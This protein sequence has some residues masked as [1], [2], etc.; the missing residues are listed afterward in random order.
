MAGWTFDFGAGAAAAGHVKVTTANAAYD[1]A[2]GW[3]FAAGGAISFRQRSGPDDERGDFC[4]PLGATFIIDAP[5]GNYTVTAL[6]GDAIAPTETVVKAAPGRLM[7]PVVRTEA[8][9]FA[10]H[11]FALRASG[12]AIRLSF[13]GSAPRLNALQIAAAPHMPTLYLAGDSTVTD[14]AEEMFPYAGWG[15][16]LPRWLKADVAVVN[17][18]KSG[19]SSRSFIGEGRLDAIAREL[20]PH[21]MLL[22]QFGHNDQKPDEER[23]T[24]PSSS[25]AEHLRRYVDVARERDVLPI[26][27]TPV[28][29]RYFLPGGELADTHGEYAEAVRRLAVE[30]DVPLV[31]LALRSKTL[32]EAL[33]PEGTKAVFM[34]AAPGE[35]MRFP[36]GVEDNTHFQE[37]GAIRIAG[38]V[39]EALKELRL[40]PLHK[41]VR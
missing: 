15:Q 12:G 11:S 8:G 7:L 32:F 5:D 20:K 35:F 24:E 1:S 31:D 10:R 34:W 38:L 17:F 19:R 36:G 16:M 6:F 29:R 14:E 25:Y 21:D 23:H 41:Y 22:V 2:R 33:G 28:Q 37:Q 3:G 30:L 39:A 9:Q 26:L 4:I 13:A 40:Q 18:A 27:V